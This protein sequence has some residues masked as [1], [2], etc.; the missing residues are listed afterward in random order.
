MR[1]VIIGAGGHGEVV[2]DI[3]RAAQLR[4]ETA[5]VIGFV[6]DRDGLLG[7][8]VVGLPVLGSMARL[9]EFGADAAVVAIGDN[10]S[11]AAVTRTLESAG[12]HLAVARH[13]SAIIAADVRIGPGAMVCAGAIVNTGTRIGRGVIL[14]TGC[15]VDHHTSVGDFAHIAPGVHM[16]G[17][18]TVGEGALVGIGAVILPRIRIGAGSI[19]GAGAVVTRDVPAGLTVTGVPARVVRPEAGRRR[20]HRIVPQSRS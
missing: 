9:D 1:I 7:T 12:K 4:G 14:N 2:A 17:E 20:P 8:Q 5:D 19:V 18:V 11:R 3:F 10:R 13:P 15:T 6:D 16:G